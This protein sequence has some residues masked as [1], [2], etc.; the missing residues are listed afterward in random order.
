MSEDR[1]AEVAERVRRETLPVPSEEELA[2]ARRIVSDWHIQWSTSDSVR[3]SSLIRRI[4]ETV[5]ASQP[6]LME[7]LHEHSSDQNISVKL[8]NELR[9]LA[10]KEQPITANVVYKCPCCGY[11]DCGHPKCREDKVEHDP[12]LCNHCG[13]RHTLMDE[14][15]PA[16][17]AAQPEEPK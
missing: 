2:V 1:K 13:E 4:A 10:A 5:K 6:S 9:A 16:L 3:D 17:G 14:C 7:W 11:P 8:W 15:P 12:S